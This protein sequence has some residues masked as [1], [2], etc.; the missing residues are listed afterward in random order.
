[1]ITVADPVGYQL[2]R[3]TKAALK[4]EQADLSRRALGMDPEPTHFPASTRSEPLCDV[5]Q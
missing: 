2:R 3:T 4:K 1:M 5:A